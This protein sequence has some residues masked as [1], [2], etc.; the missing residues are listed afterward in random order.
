MM[1]K[2]SSQRD[3]RIIDAHRPGFRLDD[4]DMRDAKQRARDAHEHE[5]TNAWRDAGRKITQRDPQGRLMSTL[6]EEEDAMPPVR[7]GRTMDQIHRDHQAN[8]ARLYAQ[9][10]A[11]QS[12]EWRRKP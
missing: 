2:D 1:A 8:M 6:E 11:E 12:D 9:Y 5:L 10:D 3:V 4:A 7:D